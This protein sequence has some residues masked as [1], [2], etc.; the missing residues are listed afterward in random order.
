MEREDCPAQFYPVLA[1][2]AV[3]THCTEIAPGS[4]V[5]E[6]DFDDGRFGHGSP[7]RLIWFDCSRIV[8]WGKRRRGRLKESDFASFSL[9]G[10]M[11]KL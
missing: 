10:F 1:L 7:P 3:G 11:D 6:K 8:G 2:Q 4:D 9:T 5:V